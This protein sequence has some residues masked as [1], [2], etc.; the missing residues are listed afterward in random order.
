M[1]TSGTRDSSH[2]QAPYS[3]LRQGPHHYT[4]PAV[5]ALRYTTEQPL[6]HHVRHS[7]AEHTCV[8]LPAA[9]YA[10]LGVCLS[11]VALPSIHDIHASA[12]MHTK[13]LPRHKGSMELTTDKLLANKLSSCLA[14][15]LSGQ[16]YW[17]PAR[18]DMSLQTRHGSR[19]GDTTTWGRT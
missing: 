1:L 17:G 13:A 9:L 16:S 10:S 14:P 18:P 15:S 3:L 6:H 12:A 4:T 2:S 7:I 8:Q 5:Q 19:T 11:Y